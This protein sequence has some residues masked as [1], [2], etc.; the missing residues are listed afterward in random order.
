M[1]HLA[2]VTYLHSQLCVSVSSVETVVGVETAHWVLG[3][4][5]PSLLNLSFPSGAP[6]LSHRSIGGGISTIIIPR[7]TWS[8]LRGEKKGFQP[9]CDSWH[10]GERRPRE[11]NAKG[12]EMSKA[13]GKT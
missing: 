8:H 11:S 4:K 10:P 13:S 5:G 2:F 7:H 3:F 6:E 9:R 1:E 12:W